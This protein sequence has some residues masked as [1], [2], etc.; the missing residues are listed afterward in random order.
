MGIEMTE[1][2]WETTEDDFEKFNERVHDMVK[3]LG[4]KSWRIITQ[5]G[6][7]GGEATLMSNERVAILTFGKKL[8]SD[9]TPSNIAVHESLHVLTAD[10]YHILHRKAGLDE[11]DTDKEI[12]AVLRPMAKIVDALME[13]YGVK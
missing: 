12:H 7:V 3:W 1:N 4:L 9:Q 11:Y 8:F 5:W 6:G 2:M 10:L 13:K